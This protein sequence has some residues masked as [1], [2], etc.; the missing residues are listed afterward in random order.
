MSA[1]RKNSRHLASENDS[2]TAGPDC[3]LVT[4]HAA[5][6]RR[7]ASAISTHA[8]AFGRTAGMLTGEAILTGSYP[9]VEVTPHSGSLTG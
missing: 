7:A 6:G 3:S 2:I 1:E 4:T 8:K 5:S 9:F